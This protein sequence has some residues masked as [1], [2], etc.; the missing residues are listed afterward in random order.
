MAN[1][2]VRIGGTLYPSQEWYDSH[3]GTP[4]PTPPI[5]A[6]ATP[7]NTPPTTTPVPAVTP[8]PATPVGTPVRIGGTLYPSQ[9]WYDENVGSGTTTPTPQPATTMPP[10]A[11]G[12][13]LSPV[14]PQTGQTTTPLPTSTY[15]GNSIV[16]YLKSVNQGSS[17][18]ERAVLAQQQGIQGYTGT[19]EQNTQLLNNLRAGQDLTAPIAGV[20]GTG[21]DTTGTAGTGTTEELPDTTQPPEDESVTEMI[22]RLEDELG[23]TDAVARIDNNPTQS[24][25][26]IYKLALQ[27]LGLDAIQ[28]ELDDA[29]AEINKATANR[30]EAIGVIRDNPWLDEAMKL[31]RAGRTTDKANAV[32]KNLTNKAILI[33]SKLNRGRE[34][35]QLLADRS[36]E[37]FAQKRGWDNQELNRIQDRVELELKAELAERKA[38]LEAEQ[39][40]YRYTNEPL[41]V[42]EAKALSVPYG[43]T[44]GEAQDMGIIPTTGGA[45]K[46]SASQIK[47]EAETQERTRVNDLLT[48]YG[49][50]ELVSLGYYNQIKASSTIS[51]NE[52][53]GRFGYLLSEEDQQKAGITGEMSMQDFLRSL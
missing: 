32:I 53:D 6:P 36:L 5:T 18:A 2:P 16:D 43:T 3:I 34:D 15:T 49:D 25:G 31:G 51:P 42:T 44:R 26:D 33:E 24:W 12:A 38:E 47:E 52:F 23:Y 1:V 41:S 14:T 48:A 10:G 22:T 39:E 27:D 4:T 9:Q 40:V 8:A 20:A 30:D 35:A 29:I 13:P 28:T 37:M 11:T 21:V 7:I 19:A 46:P 50:R 45:D 17:F